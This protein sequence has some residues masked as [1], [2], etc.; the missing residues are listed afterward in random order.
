MTVLFL[1]FFPPRDSVRKI[2]MPNIYNIAQGRKKDTGCNIMKV[3]IVHQRQRR[4]FLH[5]YLTSL[6]TGDFCQL[7]YCEKITFASEVPNLSLDKPNWKLAFWNRLF[8]LSF[9]SPSADSSMLMASL[10]S[11]REAM[12]GSVFFYSTFHELHLKNKHK[13]I[14]FSVHEITKIKFL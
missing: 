13:M 1:V 12:A 5:N 8:F 3:F 10:W 11:V 7:C 4:N 2:A 6:Q 14:S 9:G